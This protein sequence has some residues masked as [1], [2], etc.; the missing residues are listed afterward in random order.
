MEATEATQEGT[1]VK[2]E[3]T[4]NSQESN[5]RK[6]STG[7]VSTTTSKTVAQSVEKTVN[8][9]VATEK[10]SVSATSAGSDVNGDATSDEEVEEVEEVEEIVE[11]EELQEDELDDAEEASSSST[12]VVIVRKIVKKKKKK[13]TKEEKV[14]KQVQKKT[15]VKEV[16]TKVVEKKQ[17]VKP[18]VV[19][20]KEVKAAV[21]EKK[22]EVKPVVAEKKED[23]KEQKIVEKKVEVQEVKQ[24]AKEEQ[25]TKEAEKSEEEEEVSEEEEESE[26][27]IE[28]KP[29]QRNE[30]KPKEQVE[31]KPK[32]TIEE[33]VK[34]EEKIEKKPEQK[35]EEVKEVKQQ[36]ESKSSEVKAEA[37]GVAEPTV[38][39]E[40]EGNAGGDKVK[41]TETKKLQVVEE[42]SVQSSPPEQP[43]EKPSQN[44]EIQ[45]D[46]IK[47]TIHEIIN[48]IDRQITEDGPDVPIPVQIEV[49]VQAPV[50]APIQPPVQAPV[51]VPI[52]APILPPLSSGRND[53]ARE[54]SEGD[55][56]NG[57]RVVD[58]QKI[59][60]PATDAEEIL[61]QRQRKLYASSSF[62]SPVL[63]PTVEDQVELARRISHS[64][65]DISN[66]HS[67]G[68]SMYVNRKKRSVK[69]VHEGEGKAQ[70]M[71]SSSVQESS[72]SYSHRVQEKLP[73]KLVMNPR[74][75]VQDLETLRKQ[76][77][78][79]DPTPL[80]PDRCAEVVNA[81]QAT[82]GKGAE[83][84]AKRRKKSE[85][86]VVD[87]TSRQS[88]PTTPISA[89]HN[90]PPAFTDFGV[91]RAQQNIK[92]NQIQ[93]K[94]AQPKVK[95]V[96]SPWQSALETGH[97]NEAFQMPQSAPPMVRPEPPMVR[98]EPPPPVV[99]RAAEPPRRAPPSPGHFGRDLAYRP[100]VAQGWNAP[101]PNLPGIYTPPELP[102]SSYAPPPRVDI[103]PLQDPVPSY[104]RRPEPPPQQDPIPSFIRRPAE[105]PRQASAPI[106]RTPS[107]QPPPPVEVRLPQQPKM[108]P[109]AAAPMPQTR[110][111]SAGAYTPT[112]WRN[113][114]TA[115]RGWR[116]ADI[117]KPVTFD[118]PQLPFTDF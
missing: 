92:L 15:E 71:Y 103:P 31:D 98:P 41:E 66:Q 61:P 60:T 29:V 81:L 63:H 19:E 59:F 34:I 68:Q 114:N 12:E 88:A 47:A 82:G 8:E 69:W 116:G 51:Q 89:C 86:W 94:Y 115:A 58:L 108:V 104:I 70:V 30:V 14:P 2:S 64:L 21:P 48:D 99:M 6:T 101:K 80:S 56:E 7:Q 5:V 72:E 87:E 118:K 78:L 49:P 42:T 25:V 20:K 37:N 95:I 26:P 43:P 96:K 44:G 102:L 27:E 111:A 1:T 67:K 79:I 33:N 39:K 35:I 90:V 36:V 83:L 4:E 32:E 22:E 3:V 11:E 106:L 100:N 75:Q 84:F 9:G 97:V 18:V 24:K 53:D 52:Q 76:G 45:Q 55:K 85:K 23:V 65:S 93:E 38:E 113:Y 40:R 77:V 62:Y 54:A 109:P 112:N 50:Q 46:S 10:S 73:L 16:K 28:E 117:Y 91:Q 105:P 74:G 110:I 57:P 107:V 13:T 17:E